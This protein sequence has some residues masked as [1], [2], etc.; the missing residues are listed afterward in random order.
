MVEVEFAVVQLLHYIGVAWGVGGVTI[1]M[2]VSMKADKNPE[3]APHLM[4][5]N[6]AIIKLIWIGLILLI[7]SGIA[8]P[9]IWPYGTLEY[10]TLLMAKHVLIAIL[11]LVGIVMTFAMVPKL[12]KNMPKKDEKPSAVFV[13]A[14]RNVKIGGIIGFILWYLIVILSV[15]N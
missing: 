12:M 7:I 3:S 15:V 10:T 1:N 8:Y 11:I 14:K 13:N 4:L 2:I 6:K 9:Y 5:V